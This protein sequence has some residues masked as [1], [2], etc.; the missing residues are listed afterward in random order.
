M[1]KVV[2]LDDWEGYFTNSPEIKRLQQHFEVHIFHDEP[3]YEQLKSRV[4][5][6][7]I[8]I[9]IR[10]RTSFTKDFLKQLKKIKLIAQTGGGIAHIDL[11]EAKRLQIPIATT[12]GG[13][14]AVVEL[15]FGF[16][17]TFSRNLQ[18]LNQN[19]KKGHWPQSIG[20]GLEGKTIGIIGLGKIGSGVAKIAKAFNMRVIA[21][22][23]RLTMERA[24]KQDVT[25]TSLE[26]LLAESHFVVTAVRLVPETKNLLTSYHFS[27]MREDAFFI[28]TSRGEIIDE[29]ALL[30]VLVNKKIAG[31]GLDVFSHEPIHPTH[32]LLQ[33]DNVI[34]SPHIG[35]KTDNMFN[36]FLKVSI[37]NII[38]YIIEREPKRIINPQVLP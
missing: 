33:I 38:S 31:A 11:D 37:D 12:P 17:L 29:K 5:D 3:S 2:I 16:I 4:I 22:G 23:P 13:S 34:L 19:V 1:M 30:D 32:P 35:W 24:A 7:D 15:I 8:I 25:Y 36:Q 21:W 14:S 18:I 10:E 27:L 6:A 20:V 28:N 9:P 26:Q